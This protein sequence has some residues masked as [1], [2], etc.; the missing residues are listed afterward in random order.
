[1]P[2]EVIYTSTNSLNYYND[3]S[4]SGFFAA[5]NEGGYNDGAIRFTGVAIPQG[6]DI[7][8]VGLYMADSIL[9]GS[10]TIRLTFSGVDEDNTTDFSG[11]PLSRPRTTTTTNSSTD[12]GASFWDVDITGIVEEIVGRAGWSSGNAL[13]IVA[14]DNG[15]DSGC[16]IGDNPAVGS[17]TML[18][19]RM[20][21][22]NLKPTPVSQN[23]DDLPA[24]TDYGI[25]ISYPGV[26]VLTATE[27]QLYFTTRKKVFK[28]FMQG[29]V[30]TSGA[31]QTIQHDLGY[32]PTANCFALSGGK[33]YVLPQINYGGGGNVGFYN[34]DD[35]YLYIYAGSGVQVYYYIYLDP[36]P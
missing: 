1:M 16:K 9:D 24:S 29:N 19:V 21:N 36:Q 3:S 18:S 12:A 17:N 27:D 22:P 23:T 2:N 30:T 35:T 4:G 7:N 15:S 34:L 14:E 11:N 6:A 31:E 10:G 33:R 8:R 28:V 26:S 32:V 25:K 5:G 20:T 13:A